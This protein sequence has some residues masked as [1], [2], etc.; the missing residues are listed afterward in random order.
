MINN[1][2]MMTHDKRSM[3]SLKRSGFF[4]PLLLTCTSEGITGHGDLALGI[5]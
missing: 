3:I 4:I 2:M 5:H 1:M